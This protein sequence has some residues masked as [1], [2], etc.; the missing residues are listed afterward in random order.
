MRLGEVLAAEVL[1]EAAAALVS[2]RKMSRLSVGVGVDLPQHTTGRSV[3]HCVLAWEAVNVHRNAT[4]LVCIMRLR[5]D[6]AARSMP[7]AASRTF[8]STTSR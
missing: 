2:A 6:S 7:H 1:L 8:S 3:R 5:S 4:V